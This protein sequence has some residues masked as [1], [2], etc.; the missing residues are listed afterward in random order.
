MRHMLL[1]KCSLFYFFVCQF[2]VC[3]LAAPSLIVS[4]SYPFGVD[5][6]YLVSHVSC[7]D[8]SRCTAV[9]FQRSSVHDSFTPSFVQ[10]K[11]FT[12][13]YWRR[14]NQAIVKA[15]LVTIMDIIISQKNMTIQHN[16]GTQI[17]TTQFSF[18]FLKSWQSSATRC[19]CFEQCINYCRVSFKD[20]YVHTCIP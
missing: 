4:N 8:W 16:N 3:V 13:Q 6:T 2:F 11:S 14:T 1:V 18:I 7:G 5:Q 15:T 20:S 9:N 12:S 10:Q 17:C 19:S